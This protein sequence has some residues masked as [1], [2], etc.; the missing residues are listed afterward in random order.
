MVRHTSE[1]RRPPRTR[2]AVR[3]ELR[4]QVDRPAQL[5]NFR[6]RARALLREHGLQADEREAVVLAAAE[7]LNNALEACATADCHIE[8]IISLVGDF[9]CVEV[10]DADERF[11][12]VCLDVTMP[13][14]ADAEH[15]R[16]LYLMRVM[17]ESLELVPRKRGT[18]VRMVKRLEARERGEE[19]GRSQ[20]LG[21][22]RPGSSRAA[23]AAEVRE[24]GGAELPALP[25]PL[26]HVSGLRPSRR[27]PARPKVS[28]LRRTSGRGRVRV[29]LHVVPCT[30]RQ[31]VPWCP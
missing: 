8:A 10:R 20:T 9:V 30:R 2:S 29:S 26:R 25:R 16:G 27:R 6:R 7:A 18:L 13:P 11:R 4:L 24:A 1:E 28:A 19:T 14:D 21:R 12:G 15:G 31:P 3:D 5:G 22:L 23:P 17:M